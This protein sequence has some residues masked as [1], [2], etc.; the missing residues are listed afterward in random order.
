MTKIFRFNKDD[1]EAIGKRIKEIRGDL[2][3]EEFARSL[4]A[5]KTSIGNYESARQAPGL[6]F[7]M[8]ICDNY[9]VEPRWLIKGHGPIYDTK[10]IES[11][12]DEARYNRWMCEND[13]RIAEL[14]ETLALTKEKMLHAQEMAGEYKSLATSLKEELAIVRLERDRAHTEQEKSFKRWLASMEKSGELEA[15]RRTDSS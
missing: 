8:S 4:G 2:S 3:Q 12:E 14:E 10:R 13:V 15:Y 7:I 1:I 6:F 9:N 5:S 11:V